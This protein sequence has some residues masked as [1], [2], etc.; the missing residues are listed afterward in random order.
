MRVSTRGYDVPSSRSPTPPPARPRLTESH[1]GHHEQVA[2]AI[3][4]GIQYRSRSIGSVVL[5]PAGAKGTSAI[6]GRG[7]TGRS[8]AS[9]NGDI[10]AA[11]HLVEVS[12][13]RPRSLSSKAS[14][15][16]HFGGLE[17]SPDRSGT[18]ARSIGT[19][20]NCARPRGT[21]QGERLGLRS[22]SNCIKRSTTAIWEAPSGRPSAAHPQGLNGRHTTDAWPEIKPDVAVSLSTTF[23][24]RFAGV[25]RDP[26]LTASIRRLAE[27]GS[28]RWLVQQLPAAIVELVDHPPRVHDVEPA[29]TVIDQDKGH[30]VRFESDV[31]SLV[32]ALGKCR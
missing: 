20:G 25:I 7:K 15:N 13:H 17:W 29:A 24:K 8:G 5:P 12:S 2:M 19:A 32:L 10:A 27:H 16:W 1:G 21:P 14:V 3:S 18:S 26:D 31:T 6:E 30:L 23:Y 22:G 4:L 11:R 28:A 9:R